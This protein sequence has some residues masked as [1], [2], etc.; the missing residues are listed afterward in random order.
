M[1]IFS[2]F[3]K[4]K[5]ISIIALVLVVILALSALR[6]GGSDKIPGAETLKRVNLV[7]VYDFK[8]EKDY[9]STTGIVETKGQADLKSQ[10]SAPVKFVYAEVGDIVNEGDIILELENSDIRA[11][12]AQAEALLASYEGQYRSSAIGDEISKNNAIDKIRDSYIKGYDVLVSQ[13]EPLLTNYDGN[14][15]QLSSMSLDSDISNKIIT[16]RIDLR[17]DLK[18]WKRSV[19]SLNENSSADDIQKSIDLSKKNLR[20][21]DTLLGYIS[22]TLNDSARHSSG[23]F[24]TFLNTWKAVVSQ[25]RSTISGSISTIISVESGYK[26]AN[27]SLDTIAIAQV[28]AGE[29]S[30]NNLKAQLAK[31]I[32]V[33][34]V[35][36][37]ISSL[38]LAIGELASP[39]TLLATVISDQGLEV[40]SFISGQDLIKIKNGDKAIISNNVDGEV[41]SVAPSVSSINKKAEVKIAIASSTATTTKRLTIGAIVPVKIAITKNLREGEVISYK[42][43]IQDVKIIPGEAYVLTVDEENKIKKYSVLL[44]EVRGDFVEVVGGLDDGMKIVS[45]VY[46]LDE[47]EEV[48]VE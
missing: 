41:Y 1:S 2:Y 48:I 43:P 4:H 18:V 44:G 17:E 24:T 29:A 20:N 19:D 42:L 5:I 12:L 14:G 36:G 38:P 40:K 10:Y 28:S 31:T 25:A 27:N 34:P 13:I 16:A 23:T 21:I 47:G 35:K 3:K 33:S 15:G 6:K 37:K 46:E 39:G 9:I 11:Q 30:V 22:E 32:V 8:N 7:S 45:P 26:T